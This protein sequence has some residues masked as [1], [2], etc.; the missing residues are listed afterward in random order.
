MKDVTT[1]KPSESKCERERGQRQ[2]EMTGEEWQVVISDP[3][4]QG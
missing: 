3:I 4:I 1:L 2:D